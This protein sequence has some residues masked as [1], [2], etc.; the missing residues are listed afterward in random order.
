[1]SDISSTSSPA[2]KLSN[3]NLPDLLI[4]EEVTP[5]PEILESISK[6]EQVDKPK[7]LLQVV[8]PETLPQPLE[9]DEMQEADPKS[10]KAETEVKLADPTPLP[11]EVLTQPPGS[12]P[13]PLP[14][15]ASTQPPASKPK[16]IIVRGETADAPRG[17]AKEV[18][19][20]KNP[21]TILNPPAA[22]AKESK[23]KEHDSAPEV[24][25]PKPT[26]LS[27]RPAP[28]TIPEVVE[29]IKVPEKPPA[30]LS[31]KVLEVELETPPPEIKPERPEIKP[32]VK[33]EPKSEP[34]SDKA[35]PA[36]FAVP[37]AFSSDD[38]AKALQ[39][40]SVQLNQ[41]QVVSGKVVEHDARGA[42]IEVG[43]KS[44]G[45]LPL[46]E[47]V[48]GGAA[49]LEEALPV[50]TKRDFV[51]IREADGDG[52]VTLSVKSFLMKQ[53]WQ[54]LRQFQTKN[55]SFNCRIL[56]L[57]TGGLVVS[58]QGWRGFI[59]RSHLNT[60]IEDIEQ[61]K[62]T[63]IPVV[64][65]ELDE[66]RN[67]IVLSNRL[68][69]K[70]SAFSQ[71]QKGQLVSGTV[72]SIRPFGLFVELGGLTGLLHVKEISQKYIGNPESTFPVG[73]QIRAVV[74]DVDESRQRIA[75]STK[76]LELH[77]G[78]ILEHPEEV[79]AEAEQRLEKNISKLWE[80]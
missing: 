51:I 67:K 40:H 1:M 61:V 23:A 28:E 64:I 24:I 52:A 27:I 9:N 47:A 10:D 20:V 41:G 25:R 33:S 11:I 4:Q 31:A 12:E 72:S 34:K 55:Q 15:Q 56:E 22:K 36:I 35:E 21:K 50:G 43:G 19:A 37:K 53:A 48:L 60:Q 18:K 17:T 44:P 32:E 5:E 7:P 75:L 29:P 74:L 80:S 39:S 8:S 76:I 58:A 63:T 54:N 66:E 69:V 78:E 57:N 16:L 42:Y 70:S 79:F 14:P 62:G 59:P 46:D 71:V 77:S 68:A 49:N 45:F 2:N 38:F 6:V 30:K 26:I 73:A 3:S 65:L 13:I